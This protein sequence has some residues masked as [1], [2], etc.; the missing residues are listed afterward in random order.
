MKQKL[1]KLEIY[2]HSPNNM[3]CDKLSIPITHF[4]SYNYDLFE[5]LNMIKAS[6]HV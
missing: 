3:R 6:S 2:I 1:N 4:P 5:Q